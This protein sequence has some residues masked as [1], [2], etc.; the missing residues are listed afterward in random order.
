MRVAI[1][2]LWQ[3]TN[4]FNPLRTT[5]EQFEQFGVL[6]GDEILKRLS[7]TNEV[8]GMIQSL[9]SWPERPEL[10]GLV[11]LPAWPAG[12]ATPDTVA[13]LLDEML[14]ALQRAVPVDAVLLAL[15]GALAGEGEPDVEGAL[16]QAVRRL[17]G[18]HI[19]L[20]ATLDLH[21]NITRRIVEVTD[22]LVVYHTAPHIDVF[23][24]GQRAAAVL[25]RIL[26]DG[27][28]PVTAFQKVP[29]VFPAERANTQDPDSVSHRFR[30]QL[31]ALEADS[32]ILTA[33]LATV[34]PWLDVPE[35]GSAVVVVADG[36]AAR[37][38]AACARLATDV[39]H[40]RR[41]Y[42]P[43]LVPLEEAVRQAYHEADGLVV[44]SDSADATTSGA[45]GDSTWVLRELLKYDWPRPA[46]VTLVSPELVADAQRL[47]VGATLSRPVGGV[48]DHRFST[49]LPVTAEIVRLF[50]AR[51]VMNGHLARNLPIDMGPSAV[52][53]VGKVCIVVT[54]RTGPHFAPELFRAAGFDPLAAAVL[55]A[56]SPCGFRAAY[57]PYARR[58]I[59]V[60]APGCAPS[61]FWNYEYRHIPRPLWPWDESMEW[62]P[63]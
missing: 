28:K 48:R 40:H 14:H 21:A 26:V 44:L 57:A 50:E 3:E 16:L 45:P 20:V 37:A 58:I 27:A 39:W 15:H 13:W 23:E 59:V 4:T 54:S 41:D 63:S 47:G 53:R 33:G 36:D 43:E 34:Q 51:F 5:R 8:G 22:A 2:Q 11:R 29:A 1:G 32:A 9:R 25:R 42:L 7:E 6:R 35:L 38:H 18:P 46:L 30:Q 10:V 60:R 19:P 55:V 61:D 49:P 17:V 31:Q 12:P 52:L 24:T 56:K 62:T